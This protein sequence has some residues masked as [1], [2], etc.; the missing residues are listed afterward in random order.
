MASTCLT[1]RQISINMNNVTLLGKNHMWFHYYSS[2]WYSTT[3]KIYTFS[4]TP[5]LYNPM[6]HGFTSQIHIQDIL[7][8][9]NSMLW[10]FLHAILYEFLS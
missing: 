2:L 4:Y 6:W 9:E 10:I 3:C 1:Q 5:L 8:Q 7:K